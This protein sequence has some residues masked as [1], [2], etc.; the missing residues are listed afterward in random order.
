M[1][2][3]LRIREA[4]RVALLFCTQ[5]VGNHDQLMANKSLYYEMVQRFNAGGETDSTTD[6]PQTPVTPK[7]VSLTFFLQVA[8]EYIYTVLV[9]ARFL[10]FTILHFSSWT[11]KHQRAQLP[12]NIVGRFGRGRSRGRLGP[13]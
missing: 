9:L 5:E 12:G 2:Y 3:C 4:N 10:T 8:A 6:E 1:N 11:G 7:S 13:E